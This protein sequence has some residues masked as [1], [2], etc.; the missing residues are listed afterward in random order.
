MYGIA[1]QVD[2]NYTEKEFVLKL[3]EHFERT[4]R[5]AIIAQ[6]VKDKT[7]LLKILNDYDNDDQRQKAKQTFQGKPSDQSRPTSRDNTQTKNCKLKR[8]RNQ[9]HQVARKMKN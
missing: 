9:L 8:C 2:M 7:T 4:I 1:K 5:H 6:Q 3:S